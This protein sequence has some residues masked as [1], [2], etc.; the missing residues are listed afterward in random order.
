MTFRMKDAP[1]EHQVT[2]ALCGETSRLAAEAALNGMR[3]VRAWEWASGGEETCVVALRGGSSR[4]G[5]V[6]RLHECHAGIFTATLP[7]ALHRSI[8][9]RFMDMLRFASGRAAASN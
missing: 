1:R 8:D 4:T 7:G 5:F 6:Q 9:P 2:L 3:E